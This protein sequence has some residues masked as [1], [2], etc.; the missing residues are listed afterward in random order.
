VK[1]L[2]CPEQGRYLRLALN[3]FYNG[4]AASGIG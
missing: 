2:D 4:G 3:G 1:P